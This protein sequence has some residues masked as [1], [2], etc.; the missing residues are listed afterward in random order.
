MRTALALIHVTA[1]AT[2]I[3]SSSAAL[4]EV[5]CGQP[6]KFRAE[7]GGFLGA[8]YAVELKGSEIQ[9]SVLEPGSRDATVSTIRATERE[10]CEFRRALHEVGVWGWREEYLNP[11]VLDG[12]HWDL[13]IAYEDNALRA[14]GVN[15]FPTNFM[16]YE[17]AVEK[18]LGGKRFR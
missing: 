4:A 7:I 8:S 15:D 12:T 6:R 5:R 10:W 13:D 2:V 16:G 17:L 3:L 18:L 1:I 14:R 9:Y 11:N